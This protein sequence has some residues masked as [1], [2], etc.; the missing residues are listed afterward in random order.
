ME[1]RHFQFLLLI[2]HHAQDIKIA[3]LQ[4]KIHLILVEA[5]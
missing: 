5:I 2:A 3:V 4:I 1:I